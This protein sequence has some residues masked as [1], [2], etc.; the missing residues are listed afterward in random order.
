MY[1]FPTAIT[2]V[3]LV[4]SIFLIAVVTRT[5]SRFHSPIFRYILAVFIIILIDS[6]AVI[7]SIFAFPGLRQ[8]TSL[9]YITSE[10]VILLLFYAAVVKGR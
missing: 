4:L 7:I 10:L 1:F 5:I 2:G 9:L 6:L 3:S 8:I